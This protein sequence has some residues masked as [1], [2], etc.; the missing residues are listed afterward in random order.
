MVTRSVHLGIGEIFVSDEP[1]VISTILGSCVSV[2]MFTTDGKTGGIIHFALPDRSYANGHQRNDLHFGDLAIKTLH[3]EIVSRGVDPKRLQAK[4]AGGA[5]VIEH[6]KHSANIGD[7]NIAMA[8]ESL[9]LLKV[10]LV[11]EHVGG[12]TGRKIY[13]YTKSGRLRVALLTSDSASTEASIEKKAPRAT[14][15]MIAKPNAPAK[16]IDLVP[17]R[18]RNTEKVR[19]FIVDDSKTI[20]DI[21]T[22]LLTCSGIEVVGTAANPVEAEPLIL[23]LKPDVITLDIHMPVMD[24]VTFLEHFLPRHPIPVVMVTSINLEEV[25]PVFKA[26]ELGAVDYIQKPSFA[27]MAAQTEVIREKIITAS[28][29]R[30]KQ[31]RAP[32]I[33]NPKMLSLKSSQGASDQIIFIG[34]STGGTEAIKKVLT[35]M[36]VNIP[37]ILIVQHIPPV[38]STAFANRLNDLCQFEV[39][40]AHDGDNVQLGR[41]LVAPGDKQMEIQRKGSQYSV[42]VFDGEKVNRHRPS[43][44]VLFNSAAEVI[45]DK[46]IG[47][48]LTGMGTDGAKGLLKMRQKGARTI[49][50]DET[51]S[52]VYGMPKA[53]IAIKAA[54]EIRPLEEIPEALIRLIEQKKTA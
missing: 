19:V 18:S 48:I 35:R 47:V 8:K 46:A 27:E 5:N 23:R 17:P 10:P 38:F 32:Q 11:G 14:S 24:G 51:T 26:L 12:Q 54:E 29:I 45:K 7:L 9:S 49:S 1:A 53:A 41:V 39:K 28:K 42:R 22:R 33:H 40:E 34:A 15:G 16:P 30:L 4:I 43:V 3:D 50:Q 13:F 52:V 2:C 44:D 6:I 20:R 31:G 25:G 37:P 21:L 36:P